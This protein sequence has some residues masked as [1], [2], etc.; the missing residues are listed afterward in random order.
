MLQIELYAF[1]VNSYYI[2]NITYFKKLS[3]PWQLRLYVNIMKTQWYDLSLFESNEL[4][5]YYLS[6]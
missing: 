1:N 4:D 2:C 6:M 5:K 3:C